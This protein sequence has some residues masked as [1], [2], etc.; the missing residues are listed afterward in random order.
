MDSSCESR[1]ADNEVYSATKAAYTTSLGERA[2]GTQLSDKPTPMMNLC[3][4]GKSSPDALRRSASTSSFR[5]LSLPSGL[6]GR[7]SRRQSQIFLASI[8]QRQWMRH[9]Q[10]CSVW[11]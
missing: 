3:Q 5:F 10:C 1:G 11:F 6:S 8:P 9:F 2:P 7:G 4:E